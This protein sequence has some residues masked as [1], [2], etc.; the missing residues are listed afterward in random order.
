MKPNML[1]LLTLAAPVKVAMAEVVALEAGKT[2]PVET[3]VGYGVMIDKL[4]T[5]AE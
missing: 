1:G 4:P 3:V 2:V 5:G